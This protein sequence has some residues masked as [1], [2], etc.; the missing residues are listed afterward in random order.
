MA[1]MMVPP[2][3]PVQ[4]YFYAMTLMMLGCLVGWAWGCAAMKAAL[5]VRNQVLLLSEIKKVQ[6]TYVGLN[7]PLERTALDLLKHSAAASANPDAMFNLEVFQGRFLDTRYLSRCML[8]I[9]RCLTYIPDLVLSTGPFSLSDASSLQSRAL[10]FPSWHCSVFLGW[11]NL[12]IFITIMLIIHR[13]IF[14]D[15][16]CVSF[17]FHHQ[18][19]MLIYRLQSYGPLFPAANYMIL[20][21]FLLATAATTA[22]GC[23]VIVLVFPESLNHQMLTG[24]SKLLGCLHRLVEIQ[25]TVLTTRD[26]NDLA[27]GSK[28]PT[29]IQTMLAAVFGGM[30]KCTALFHSFYEDKTDVLHNS[31]CWS[32]HALLGI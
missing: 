1:S 29:E 17:L 10:I 18:T 7:I 28:V 8:S 24:V 6:Q 13:T 15:I 23:A 3:I 26:S 32:T 22:I 4:V 2:A 21:S 5:T 12:H 31:E 9:Y 27:P 25:E 19:M 30:E 11:Y 20:R 14:V 16:I